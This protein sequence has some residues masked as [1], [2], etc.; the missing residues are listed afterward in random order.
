MFFKIFFILTPNFFFSLHEPL[1]FE[2]FK[3]VDFKYSNSVFQIL[4][5]KYPERSFLVLSLKPF[6]FG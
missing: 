1:H 4:A 3:G 5:Q 2:K 6:H